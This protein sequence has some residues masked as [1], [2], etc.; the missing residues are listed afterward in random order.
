MVSKEVLDFITSYECEPVDSLSELFMMNE[1]YEQLTG[2][3]HRE[4]AGAHLLLLKELQSGG[5]NKD[6]FDFTTVGRLF[7]THEDNG[8]T[9]FSIRK[10]KLLP[11]EKYLLKGIICG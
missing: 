4:I 9:C 11:Y 5:H 7:Y 6:S 3:G 1:Y 8:V 2:E 10:D